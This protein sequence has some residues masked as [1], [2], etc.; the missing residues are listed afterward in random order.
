MDTKDCYQ[1]QKLHYHMKQKGFKHRHETIMVI[2][3]TTHI[4]YS[5][6][7]FVSHPVRMLRHLQG[8]R[9]VQ[10]PMGRGAPHGCSR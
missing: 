1:F 10:D 3:Q 4:S 5:I 7:L 9:L 8:Q 2:K 6:I